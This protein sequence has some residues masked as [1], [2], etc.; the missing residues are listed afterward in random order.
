MTRRGRSIRPDPRPR[1]AEDVVR[2]VYPEHGSAPLGYALRLTRDRGHAEV[3]AKEPV[4]RGW[5]HFE[6]PA[7]DGRS[8][9]PWLFAVVTNLTAGHGRTG[10]AR[11]VEM[12]ADT[13]VELPAV[14][15]LDRAVQ[16]WQIA[17]AL[18]G[19]SDEHRSVLLKTYYCWH[20]V[21]EAAAEL[22]IPVGTVKSRSYY[23]LRSV[24]LALE[25]RGWDQ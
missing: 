11:P 9:R 13:L 24:R 20:S 12:V 16:A 25:E 23:A 15:D 17:D 19:L 10:R 22:H 21:T 7:G 8:L 1:V 18:R 2:T 14:D 4:L 3:P 6:Q 5:R